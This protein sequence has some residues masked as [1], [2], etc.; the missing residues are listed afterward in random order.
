MKNDYTKA[1]KDPGTCGETCKKPQKISKFLEAKK[2][3]ENQKTCHRR[4][5]AVA[6]VRG[7]GSEET[8]RGR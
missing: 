4:R 5:V 3:P 1:N 8:E 7:R 2:N 6:H